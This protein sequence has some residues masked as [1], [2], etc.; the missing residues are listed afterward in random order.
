M[1]PSEHK[2]PAN[3][4]EV[5]DRIQKL[6][7]L[8]GIVMEILESINNDDADIAQLSMKIA[9]DQAIVARI[10]R[11]AN[12]PFYGLSGKIDS[13]SRAISILGFNSLRGLVMAASIIN[14]LPH[15]EKS[16]DWTTF[17]RHSI[18]TAVCAKVLAK[19]AGLNPETAFTAGLLHDIGKLA[20]GVYF[21]R[22]FQLDDT[23]TMASL[24]REQAAL[25]FDHATLGGEV[26]KRWHFPVAIQQAIGLH[27]THAG[28]IQER[29]LADVVYIANLF[30]H[31]LDAG[32]I[33]QDKAETLAM[34]AWTRLEFKSEMLE[35]LAGEAQQLYDS[36]IPLIA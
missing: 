28:V 25:G 27:H 14:V 33:K 9:N 36:I 34:E 4:S 12:S 11:V 31:A 35:N 17:W 15:Q 29:T 8:P 1:Q 6:P 24:Q 32:H 26:A 20:I 7:S 3:I 21:P 30:A 13:I 23:C 16:L 5:L 10:L 22:L 18:A 2:T 19:H